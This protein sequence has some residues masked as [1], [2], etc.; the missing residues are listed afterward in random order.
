MASSKSRL[1]E[2]CAAK[3]WHPPSF[4]CCED[5]PGHKK[6]YAFK[7]TI[8]VQLEGSTTILECHGAPK[9][10]KKM[11]EQHATEGALWYLMHLGIINGH[12]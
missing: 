10:K 4:E 6:L 3:H 2:I 7:V 11:A 12:N 1:Y 5:G 9:S 8:E